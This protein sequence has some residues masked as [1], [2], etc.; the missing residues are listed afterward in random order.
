[1]YIFSKYS[2]IY[3]VVVTVFV[4]TILGAQASTLIFAQLINQQGTTGVRFW[5][6][7]VYD[8]YAKARH[9]GDIIDVNFLLEGVT[10]TGRVVPIP[11]ES[12]GLGFWHY[13]K[14]S[15]NLVS[16][17]EKAIVTMTELLRDHYPEHHFVELRVKNYPLKLTSK[18]AVPTESVVIYKV[19]VPEYK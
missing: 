19:A 13:V 7:L 15:R 9:E 6:I 2:K 4:L 12:L 16:G 3:R 14:W 17:N 1:M 11:K 10:D 5:P 8:M 18:G